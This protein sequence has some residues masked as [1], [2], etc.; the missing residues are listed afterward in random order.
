MKTWFFENVVVLLLRDTLLSYFGFDF[1]KF[2]KF[3]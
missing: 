1:Y 3:I 2:R